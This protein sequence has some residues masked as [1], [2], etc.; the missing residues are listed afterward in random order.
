MRRRC[1]I[2]EMSE[3][4]ERIW[5]TRSGTSKCIVAVLA[6]SFV[7]F[8]F[9]VLFSLLPFRFV[10]F[11][12]FSSLD[13]PNQSGRCT[14]I[15]Q[16][17]ISSDL[18]FLL[19]YPEFSRAHTLWQSLSLTSVGT[20]WWVTIGDRTFVVRTRHVQS[21]TSWKPDCLADEPVQFLCRN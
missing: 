16:F 15:T 7:P 4:V 6:L 20:V 5:S 8:P 21:Q 18:D 11:A 12:H 10:F 9:L 2:S 19:F 1:Q 14:C 3:V 17:S 13:H